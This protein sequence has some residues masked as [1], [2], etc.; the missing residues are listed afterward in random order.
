M[1]VAYRAKNHIFH[2]LE[3]VVFVGCVRFMGEFVEDSAVW[4]LGAK[5]CDDAGFGVLH[6]D[7][8]DSEGQEKGGRGRIE[9]VSLSWFCAVCL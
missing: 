9:R 8:I 1:E 2:S 6:R 5:A 7:V 3:K 4:E